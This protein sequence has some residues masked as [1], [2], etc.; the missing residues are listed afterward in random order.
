M[1][2]TT[3]QSSAESHFLIR[4]RYFNVTRPTL[5]VLLELLRSFQSERATGRVTINFSQGTPQ[6]AHFEERQ[7]I[8][9][10]T[11]SQ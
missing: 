7:K 5:E 6:S 1:A 4:E 2:T 11:R 9:A 10:H 8:T 3:V